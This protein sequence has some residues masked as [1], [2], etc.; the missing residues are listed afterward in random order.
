MN[1][2]HVF[3]TVAW[4]ITGVTMALMIGAGFYVI[5]RVQEA[6]HAFA[7]PVSTVAIA[8]GVLY[9]LTVVLVAWAFAHTLYAD[10][11]SYAQW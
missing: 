2:H 3:M 10:K 4:S 6:V 1:P 5:P 8:L 7:H 9:V 11:R